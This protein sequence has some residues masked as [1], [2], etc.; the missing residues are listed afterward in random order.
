[1]A[2]TPTYWL[3]FVPG[4][5]LA[6]AAVALLLIFFPLAAP[7]GAAGI[8]VGLLGARSATARTFHYGVAAICGLALISSA[9]MWALLIS[10]GVANDPTAPPSVVERAV[11][12]EP[13]RSGGMVGPYGAV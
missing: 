12:D 2:T 7:V 13:A 1:M 8:V 9:A 10:T 5:L 6:A 11:A 3:R 4:T